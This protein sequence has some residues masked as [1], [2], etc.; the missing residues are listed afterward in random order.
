M[1]EENRFECFD[2]GSTKNLLRSM[3]RI[4][5]FDCVNRRGKLR[6]WVLNTKTN[7]VLTK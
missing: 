5:C 2:C 6:Y 7:Q 4:K 3:F 1:I